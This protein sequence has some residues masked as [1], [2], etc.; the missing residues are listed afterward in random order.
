[1]N[2]FEK[3]IE[4]ISERSKAAAKI[5]D[6]TEE[7]TK[8]AVIMPF[9]KTLGFD[10][11]NPNEVIPEFTCDYGEKKGEKVDFAIKIDG[12]IS[13]LIE[14]KPI[15]KQLGE[16]KNHSQLFRYFNVTGDAR[17]AILTNGREVWFFSDTKKLNIMDDNPFLI[18][19][20][21]NYDKA[22]VEELARFQKENFQIDSIIEAASN[23]KYIRKAAEFLKDQLDN[24]ND[25]F[26]KF[27]G[28]QIHDG[29]LTKTVFQNIKPAITAG[30]DKV[31]RDRIQDNLRITLK[32]SK[33]I[34]SKETK[35][36]DNG[37][38]TTEDKSEAFR[39]VRAIAASIKQGDRVSIKDGQ[40]YCTIIMD[41]NIRKPIC[42]LYF[43]AIRK[44]RIG[45]FNAQKKETKYTVNGPE[46]LN[47]HAE[48]IKEVIRSYM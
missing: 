43:K 20:F 2:S 44:K 42:R 40:T 5:K 25:D 11:Y 32:D 24:P 28:K 12:K 27:I 37:I 38:V 4:D 8:T 19:D 48:S 29:S 34:K 3:K 9:L 7:M 1:M 36:S 35:D 31:I 10:V 30:L 47:N 18:F 46:D 15:N 26:V 13:M 17:I 41:K 16:Q 6:I 14:A 21:Q 23:L 22:Q 45:I 39:I 33:Q